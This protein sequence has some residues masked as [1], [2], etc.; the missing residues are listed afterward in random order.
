MIVVLNDKA[1]MDAVVFYHLL[2]PVHQILL[3]IVSHCPGSLLL[4]LCLLNR[5]RP[6]LSTLTLRRPLLPLRSS[7]SVADALRGT[8]TS[9]STSLRSPVGD[10]GARWVKLLRASGLRP[11]RTAEE[12]G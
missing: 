12:P 9:T 3:A 10:A 4:R 11:F 1:V 7:S 5:L 6:C 8:L 2:R